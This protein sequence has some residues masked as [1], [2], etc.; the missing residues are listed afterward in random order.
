MKKPKAA[1][2]SIREW[3]NHADLT[4]YAVHCT[5]STRTDPLSAKVISCQRAPTEGQ[6]GVIGA[7]IENSVPIIDR[8]DDLEPAMALFRLLAAAGA[9]A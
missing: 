4:G 9:S 3:R 7:F 6:Y 2:I 1:R 5:P 8:F